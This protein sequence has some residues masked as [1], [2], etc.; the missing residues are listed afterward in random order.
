MKYLSLDRSE[1]RRPGY[2][3]LIKEKNI[4]RVFDLVRG[5][6]CASRAELVRAMH[7]SATTISALVEELVGEGLLLETGPTLTSLPGR[8]PMSLRLNAAGR[9]LAA[10]SLSRRGA[11]FTLMDLSCRTLESFFVEHPVGENEPMD[12]GEEYA[13]LFEDV[14]LHR[15]QLFDRERA[16]MVGVCFP[17]IRIEEEQAFSVRTAM[18]ISFSEASMRVLEQRLGVPL[19]LG[20]VSMCLAYAEKKNLDALTDGTEETRDLIFINV[21]DGVGAGIIS[22]GAILTG[23]YNTA[24]EFGHFSVDV[25]GPPC[26]CGNRGCLEQYVNLNAILRSAAEACAHSGV[27]APQTF[28][29]L[30]ERAPGLDAVRGVLE[31]TADR[32][33]LGIY[34][35]MCATGIR[36]VV[37]GGGIELLG[38]DFLQMVS[39]RVRSRTLLTRHMRMSYARSGPDG[40]SVGIAQ[41]FLDKAYTI[42]SPRRQMAKTGV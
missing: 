16:I 29:E 20:N 5:G 15:S 37:L 34:T 30:A 33:A 18:S 27:P 12:S 35:L 31:A 25:N 28:A 7:L 26:T 6:R 1:D 41:Y 3:Q 17:G 9:Q 32:L 36:R 40:E 22:E 10:F 11:H 13:R 8:R 39:E 2:Q 42:T 24:G 19:F 23:P 14:L 38:P 4:K 21:C